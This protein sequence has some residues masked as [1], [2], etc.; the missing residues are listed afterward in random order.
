MRK[1][2]RFLF[3]AFLL[4]LFLFVS[5][6]NPEK[7][8]SANSLRFI[9][10]GD[11]M[12]HSTQIKAA[13]NA[14][15]HTYDYDTL[16]AFLKPVLSEADFAIAN[17]EVTLAGE[18]YTGYPRF[19]SPDDLAIACKNAGFE[20]LVTANN[21]CADRGGAGLIRTLNVLDMVGI[22]HTGTFRSEKERF[23]NNPLIL[24]KNGIK[25]ALLN[26][27]YGTNGLRVP[28]SLFV[29]RINIKQI[30]SDIKKSKAEN[31]DKIIVFFHWGTEYRLLPDKRQQ[32]L[33]HFC[34]SLQV[35]IVIG[36]HP[37]V[38]QPMEWYPEKTG[39]GT[40]L[41]V[42]SLGNLVSNQRRENTDGGAMIHFT[43]TKD[44][45]GTRVTHTG[46]SLNW[47]YR[48]YKNGRFQFFILPVSVFD[49]NRS[50]FSTR[51]AYEKMQIF[52]QKT[53]SLLKKMNIG[54]MKIPVIPGV[55]E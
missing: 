8:S 27:T 34:D 7:I 22:K 28:D 41:V 29:N 50:F 38:V 30:A 19:S 2:K 40:E 36:S 32:Y 37:H 48:P 49:D 18:P 6:Q 10:A 20:C 3:S 26:Y 17:F 9:F 52:K 44:S 12:G 11:I 54:V 33:L 43:L 55:P 45:L 51:E 53:D 25:V 21:H 15:S 47:I 5:G 31:A 1:I 4:N 42:W 46:Y 35:D 16:F 14:E 23:H 39:K 13:Y 24:S